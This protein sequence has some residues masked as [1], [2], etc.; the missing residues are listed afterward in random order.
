M[1]GMFEWELFLKIPFTLL[2][3]DYKH[4]PEKLLANFYK[5]ADATS[6]P[7]YVTWNPVLTDKPDFH[8]PEFFGELIFMTENE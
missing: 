5:C 4:L 3:V 6:M 1:L 8:R 2:G 7:H